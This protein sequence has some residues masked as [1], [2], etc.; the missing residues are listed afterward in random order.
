M[1]KKSNRMEKKWHEQRDLYTMTKK[2]NRTD[3]KWHEQRD[4]YTTTEKSN[5]MGSM[6]WTTR[7]VNA[8]MIHIAVLSHNVLSLFLLNDGQVA[9][10]FVT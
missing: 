9:L 4:L 5:R 7:T 6:T 2:S 8:S 1:T 3:K 10:Q